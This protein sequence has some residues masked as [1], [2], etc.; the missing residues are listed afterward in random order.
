MGTLDAH[1]GP[2]RLGRDE[3]LRLLSIEDVGRLAVV[4]GQ[5]RRTRRQGLKSL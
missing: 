1:S 2:E 5:P 3:Y 4:L